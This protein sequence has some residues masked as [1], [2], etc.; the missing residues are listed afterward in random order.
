MPLLTIFGDAAGL[1]GGL[2]VSNLFL[3]IPLQAYCSRTIAVLNNTTL[4]LGIYKSAVFSILITLSGCYC[5]F[6]S[7]LDAQGVGRGATKAVVAAIFLVIIADALLT[8][9]YS[10]FG[11]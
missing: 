11:Y 9:L 6:N 3:D 5:G 4:L 1:V 10:S 7:S 8:L 2:T